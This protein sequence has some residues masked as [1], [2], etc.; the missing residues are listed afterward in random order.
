MHVYEYLDDKNLVERANT[1]GDNSK[2][3]FMEKPGPKQ[4]KRKSFGINVRSYA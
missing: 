2:Y 1:L 4:R 3:L